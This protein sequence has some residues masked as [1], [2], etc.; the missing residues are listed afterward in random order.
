MTTFST[1]RHAPVASR[2]RNTTV[3]LAPGEPT[4]L[5]LRDEGEIDDTVLRRVQARLDIE[6]LRLSDHDLVE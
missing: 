6:D 5:R 4:V 1:H 2:P 3:S